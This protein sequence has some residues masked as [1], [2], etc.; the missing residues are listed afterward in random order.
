MVVRMTNENSIPSATDKI[1][2]YT[3]GSTF[4]EAESIVENVYTKEQDK[5]IYSIE[6]T[7]NH[8]GTFTEGSVVTFVDRDGITTETGR[9]LGVIND[10]NLVNQVRILEH[11]MMT[12]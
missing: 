12:L 9:V 6:I 1:V 11:T 5:G 8:I 4:K 3:P 2:Q 7:D 10:I